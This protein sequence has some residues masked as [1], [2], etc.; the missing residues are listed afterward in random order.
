MLPLLLFAL[1]APQGAAQGVGPAPAVGSAADVA[2]PEAPRLRLEDLE[3]WRAH[4]LP[5]PE[6]L[7]FARIPWE[8]TFMDGVR[9]ADQQQRPLLLW[10]M[11]GHPLGCT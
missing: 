8:P 2:L 1:A 3:R 6:D 11:N 10:L 4:L 7:R 9:L 5:D